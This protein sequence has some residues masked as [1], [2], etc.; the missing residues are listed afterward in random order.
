M[1]IS[2]GV[3]QL[4]ASCFRFTFSADCHRSTGYSFQMGINRDLSLT[5]TTLVS[6]IKTNIHEES[7][8][9]DVSLLLQRVGK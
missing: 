8:Q 5:K 1:N 6:N 4:V 9:V 3:V 2:S 7:T